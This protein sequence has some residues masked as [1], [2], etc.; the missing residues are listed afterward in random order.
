[1]KILSH[2]H[3]HSHTHSHTHTHTHTAL[4]L[5]SQFSRGPS[6]PLSGVWPTIGYLQNLGPE[7]IDLILEYSKWVIKVRLRIEKNKDFSKASLYS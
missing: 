6:G 2:T 4:Q 3:T 7:S 5:L 1:M